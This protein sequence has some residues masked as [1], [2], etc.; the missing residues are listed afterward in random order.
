[1][2]VTS[3][4]FCALLASTC[5][6]QAPRVA[7][8]S[9]P[10]TITIASKS[11]PGER[12]TVT[13]RVYDAVTA[14][15]LEAVSLYVYHT[16]IH[17]HYSANTTRSDDPRLRGYIRTDKQGRYEYSTI[18]PGPYPDARVPSHIHYVVTA[19]GYKQK[20]FEIVFEGDPFIDDRI[21]ADAKNEDSG[22]SVR[23]LERGSDG[24]LRCVQDIA[25]KR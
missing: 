10:S 16:D 11:E 22:F 24:G 18:K 9:A 3:L 13:G 12:L 21:R 19:D 20:V 14:R 6:A 15:P 7:D 5:A 17:G 8:K 4:A 25:L 2:K 23:R 1:M